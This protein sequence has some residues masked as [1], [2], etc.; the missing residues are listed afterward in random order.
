MFRRQKRDATRRKLGAAV[1]IGIAALAPATMLGC[2][3]HAA[4]T[5]TSDPAAAASLPKCEK[6]AS[7]LRRCLTAIGA[8]PSPAAAVVTTS[9]GDDATR[10]R[11]DAE[12]ASSLTKLQ[13][14]CK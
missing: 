10:A 9:V 11:L 12:C 2:S 14:A 6:Y 1:L 4:P 3:S 8:D 5:K 7:E 13:N